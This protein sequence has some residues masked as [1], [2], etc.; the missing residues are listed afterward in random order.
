MFT[1][2]ALLNILIITSSAAISM[3]KMATFLPMF[4]AAW[5]TAGEAVKVA[6]AAWNSNH[7][8]LLCSNGVYGLQHLVADLVKTLEANLVGKFGYLE[9][10]LL[11]FVN[12]VFHRF[13]RAVAGFY[14]AV[15]GHYQMT[16][17]GFFGE[18]GEMVVEIGAGDH[19][20]GQIVDIGY[21]AGFFQGVVAFHTA[22]QGHGI[23]FH[24][25]VK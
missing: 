6:V 2:E 24:T 23:G 17:Q 22:R 1:S 19:K 10:C 16:Q 18:D 4:T 8:N 11:G 15:A 3:V 13:G 14:D 5:E 21:S 7:R 25:F 12:D 9:N 20:V